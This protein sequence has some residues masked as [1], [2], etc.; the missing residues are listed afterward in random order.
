MGIVIY[1]T[2]GKYEYIVPKMVSEIMLEMWGGGGGGGQFKHVK[3]TLCL[4][5]CYL[6][7][8]RVYSLIWA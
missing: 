2:P 7:C 6:L 3:G 5:F 8:V 4:R 1:T